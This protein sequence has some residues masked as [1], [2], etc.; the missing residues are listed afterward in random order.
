MPEVQSMLACKDSRGISQ[1]TIWNQGGSWICWEPEHAL[2]AALVVNTGLQ[3]GNW[4][5]VNKRLTDL[6]NDCMVRRNVDA[7]DIASNGVGQDTGES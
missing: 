4:K 3:C 6:I 1:T 5:T 2:Q 7:S